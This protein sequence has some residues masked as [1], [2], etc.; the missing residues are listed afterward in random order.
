MKH[1]LFLLVWL[2]TSIS[3]Q[4]LYTPIDTANV[5]RRETEKNRYKS[6]VISFDKYVT[7]KYKGGVASFIKKQYADVNKNMDEDIMST[8]MIFDSRFDSVLYRVKNQLLKHNPDISSDIYFYVSRNQ[9]LNAMSL[10]NNSIIV[11]CGVF[12]YL[13]NE[14]QIAAVLSHEMA[15]LIKEHSVKSIVS[16]FEMEK[17]KSVRAD[18]RSISEQRYNRGGIAFDKYK[19]ILYESGR[20]KKNQE[21]EADSLGYQLFVKAGYPPHDYI[22]SLKLMVLYDSIRPESLDTAIYRKVFNLPDYPFNSRWLQ[23]EDFSSY[24]YSKSTEKLNADSLSSHP[25][26]KERI[27]RLKNTY[28][29]LA[30]NQ[31]SDTVSPILDSLRKV[32]RYEQPVS[33]MI[34]EDYGFGLYVCLYNLYYDESPDYYKSWLGKYFAKIYDARKR[35]CLNRYVDRIDPKT[36]PQDYQQF[37]SFIWNLS[38]DDIKHIADYYARFIK[39]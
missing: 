13:I 18:V 21:F 20:M 26:M 15:H 25:E 6:A 2:S 34:S 17:S 14:G 9:T 30:H 32:L 11:N 16:N 19:N 22:N 12:Y 24:D 27:D 28:P 35:Y 36:Q 29:E 33:F 1:Y 39:S 38:L 10:G 5:A 37:L 31:M 4:Q 7:Q 23:N 8:R 3:A